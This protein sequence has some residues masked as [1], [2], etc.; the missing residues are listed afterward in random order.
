[1]SSLSLNR[2]LL[3]GGIVFV[4]LITAIS[5]LLIQP[6]AKKRERP[7]VAPIVDV[8]PLEKGDF[9]VIVHAMGE[10]VPQLQIELT[11]QVSGEIVDTSENF[12]PGGLV[13]AGEVLLQIDPRDYELEVARQEA[14]FR[15]AEAAYEIE[16]GQQKN[17]R[18]DLELISKDG[19]ATTK[20]TYLVLRGPQLKQ[21]KAEMKR[22]GADLDKA[23]L[24]LDR[25]K[26]HA[27]FNALIVERNVNLGAKVSPQ[28]ALATL[29]NT[30][31]YWV[32]I[33]VPVDKLPWLQAGEHGT[34]AVVRLSNGR[35]ERKGRIERVEGHLEQGSRLA[36]LIVSIDDPLLLQVDGNTESRPMLLGD[37]VTVTLNGRM[38][39]GVYRVPHSYVRNGDIVWAARDEK[40][41]FV[42]VTILHK[43]REYVY[44]KADLHQDDV[45]ITSNI[46]TPIEGMPIQIN[47]GDTTSSLEAVTQQNGIRSERGHG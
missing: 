13:S 46:A 35:G 3:P 18:R 7:A 8:V 6:E 26:I 25:T 36:S 41:A 14:F 12:A 38:L 37:Y 10:V 15:Q 17:A 31:Q 2:I 5:L 24:N 9:P 4:A 32:R 23:R 16:L 45:V 22:A 30:D 21:A 27:P 29:A 11:T 19:L 34:E 43:D 1:M 28:Q 42:P 40:V 44:F 33:S 39:S 20:D 47:N